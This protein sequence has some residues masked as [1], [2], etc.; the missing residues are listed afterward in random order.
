MQVPSKAPAKI[1]LVLTAAEPISPARG[2]RTTQIVFRTYRV[3]IEA[4]RP[5]VAKD[6]GTIAPRGVVLAFLVSKIAAYVLALG[7]VDA[8]GAEVPG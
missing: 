7:R 1:W 6:V 2:Y 8:G 5:Q 4:H 3:K